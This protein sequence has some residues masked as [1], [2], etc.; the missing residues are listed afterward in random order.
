MADFM[1]DPLKRLIG[2]LWDR[3][4]LVMTAVVIV[5]FVISRIY[6]IVKNWLDLRK[7]RLDAEKARLEI[8]KLERDE[9]DGDALVRPATFDEV[10]AY[11]PKVRKLEVMNQW[12]YRPSPAP[13]PAP[14][15]PSSFERANR[16]LWTILLV[17]LIPAWLLYFFQNGGLASK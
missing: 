3:W 10:R 13:E 6:P 4:P 15:P 12:G 14:A 2:W 9:K 16:I 7:A 8:R 1:P 5:G 11:D 17:L